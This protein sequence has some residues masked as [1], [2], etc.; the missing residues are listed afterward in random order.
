[1]RAVDAG[2]LC[3]AVNR[4]AA[5]HARASRLLEELAN[6]D[7]PW[8]LPWPAVHEFLALVTHPHTVARPLRPLDAWGFVAELAHG[9]L[10]R[11][12]GPT[13]RHAAVLESV[14]AGLDADTPAPAALEL[15]VVLREHGVGEVLSTD[16]ELARFAFLTVR[17]PLRDEAFRLDDPP[18]RR[19][20]RLRP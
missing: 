16:R 15:A 9:P 14:L 10:V 7:A 4:Y 17:N 6:G 3:F 19:Y 20:R 18:A 13:A 5:E 8:A 1:V 11:W 2:L 12:L